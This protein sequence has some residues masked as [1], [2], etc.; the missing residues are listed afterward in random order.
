MYKNLT[1]RV[2]R[3][4]NIDIR[5]TRNDSCVRKAEGSATCVI[6]DTGSVE[7]AREAYLCL[8]T[9]TI[10][11][12]GEKGNHGTLSTSLGTVNVGSSRTKE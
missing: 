12:L 4:V 1:R 11:L 9:S 7:G 5:A 8:S 6:H 2:F 10:H 3:D